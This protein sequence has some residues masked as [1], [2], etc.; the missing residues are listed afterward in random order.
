MLQKH[1][2]QTWEIRF[3]HWF[4]FAVITVKLWSGFYIS[5]PHPLLGFPDLYAARM[6]HALMTPMLAALLTFRLYYALLSGD[7]R[8]VFV[9][10]LADFRELKPWLRHFLFLSGTPSPHGKYNIAQRL[11]FT[12]W[13]LT[14]PFF[15]ATGV[16]MLNLRQ[17]RFI[18]VFFGG[19]GI[20]RVTHYLLSVFLAATVA[21][22]VYMAVTGSV[23]RLR[24]MFTGWLTRRTAVAEDKERQR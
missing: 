8:Q 19:Q 2:H 3:F 17:L 7:W 24:A 6:T 15:Y 5:F 12:G 23:G 21:V 4:F 20:S 22:H 1:L 16:V 11:L 18:N 10:R 13:F 9:W 14:M